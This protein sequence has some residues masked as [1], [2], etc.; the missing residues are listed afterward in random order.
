MTNASLS[1][2]PKRLILNAP[3]SSLWII[4][5][6][7]LSTR[8]PVKLTRQ[9]CPI[10]ATDSHKLNLSQPWHLGTTPADREKQYRAIRTNAAAQAT[11]PL[12]ALL[13][14]D[15]W[16]IAAAPA[17][18]SCQNDDPDLPRHRANPKPNPSPENSQS[19][20]SRP[21]PQQESLLQVCGRTGK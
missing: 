19:T 11:E 20:R 3:G 4:M 18:T 13:R 21:A 12:F 5:T 8:S 2:N 15:T 9:T 14:F 16:S 7:T 1:K 6:A 10:P 17:L